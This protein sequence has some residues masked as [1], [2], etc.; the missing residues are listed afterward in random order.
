MDKIISPHSLFLSLFLHSL[1]LSV[2]LEMKK[3]ENGAMHFREGGSLSPDLSGS[4][5]DVHDISTEGKVP[6]L[7]HRVGHTDTHAVK[8]AT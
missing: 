1:S 4:T 7:V 3:G 5:C 8:T 2:S 6:Y